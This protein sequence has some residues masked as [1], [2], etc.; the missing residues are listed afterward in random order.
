MNQTNNDN[1][2]D[3]IVEYVE[4]NTYVKFFAIAAASVLGL[5]LLGNVFKISAH[6]IRGF[7]EM[8]SA[9]QGK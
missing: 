6:C 8:K 2:I 4:D 5:Y 1:I 3:S 9:W 7:N